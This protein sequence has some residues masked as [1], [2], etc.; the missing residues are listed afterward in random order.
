MRVAITAGNGLAREVNW[1]T[2]Q[3]EFILM[4]TPN[5]DLS[6]QRKPPIGNSPVRTVLHV[7]EVQGSAE[8][9]WRFGG[10][11]D[12]NRAFLGNSRT[13]MHFM[14]NVQSCIETGDCASR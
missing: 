4:N 14:Q 2:G 9:W 6:Q 10:G 8:I 5:A 1:T 12:R 7:A 3:R 11:S 13:S